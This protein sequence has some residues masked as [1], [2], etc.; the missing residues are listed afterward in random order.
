MTKK[1][2][3]I[4]IYCD[5]DAMEIM[6]MVNRAIASFDLVFVDTSPEGG[7][8]CTFELKRDADV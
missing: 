6:E 1:K 3:E 4:T 7:D 5:T 8:Y 2:R